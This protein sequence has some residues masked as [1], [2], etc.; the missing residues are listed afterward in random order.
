MSKRILVWDIPI[1]LYHW[2][3][4]VSI[5]YAWLAIEILE[6]VEQHLRAGYTALTLIVFRIIWGFA[7]T[8][9][10][11]FSSFSY[12]PKDIIAYAKTLS[13]K[14]SKRFLGHNPLGSISVFFFIFAIGLQTLSGLFISDDYYFGAL[15]YFA[16][17]NVEKVFRLIHEWN[18]ELITI[19]IAVHILMIVFY[20]IVK[21]QKLAAAMVHGKKEACAGAAPTTK[22]EQK[23]EGQMATKQTSKL[24]IATAILIAC[25]GGVY[26]L[27]TVLP[28]PP[29]S[30]SY[31]FY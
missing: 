17:S 14:N 24:F 20:R 11:Q 16:S 6:D 3:L 31:S 25:A 21:K 8:H 15:N 5:F 9:Y 1:R 23:S 26:L 2:L 29:A 4:V 7:G 27:A 18:F 22:V 10:A 13:D 30:E 19:L 12:P 28:K